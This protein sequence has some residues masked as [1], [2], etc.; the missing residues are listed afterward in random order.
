MPNAPRLFAPA[1]IKVA[2]I[3]LT[4]AF[5]AIG[6]ATSP[7]AARPAKPPRPMALSAALITANGSDAGFATIRTSA[8]HNVLT[9]SLHG[10]KP[11]EHGVHFHTIGKCITPDFASAGG[12][13]NPAGHQHGTLNPMGSHLGD[14]PN[15]TADASGNASAEVPLT[16]SDTDLVKNLLDADGTAI[17]VH[18]GPDDYKTDPSGKSGARIACGVFNLD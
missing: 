4:V 8:G 13:L 9:L 17:V 12:H 15:V 6:L 14:L 11:G 3:T 16:I 7:L 10:L 2:P 1:A 18:A 5:A